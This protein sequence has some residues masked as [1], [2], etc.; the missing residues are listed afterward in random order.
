MALLQRM[1][2]SQFEKAGLGGLYNTHSLVH[3]N[4]MLNMSSRGYQ[5]EPFLC[6]CFRL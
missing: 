3:R 1:S 2:D 5:T 4:H 6:Q